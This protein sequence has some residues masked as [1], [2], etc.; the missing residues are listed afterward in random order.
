MVK[1]LAHR[2]RLTYLSLA[3]VLLIAKTVIGEILLQKAYRQI[4]HQ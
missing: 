4:E 1:I 2:D 3:T